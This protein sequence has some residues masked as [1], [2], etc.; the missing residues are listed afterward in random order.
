MVSFTDKLE[1]IYPSLLEKDIIPYDAY[2]RWDSLVAIDSNGHIAGIV[3]AHDGDFYPEAPEDYVR[4]IQKYITNSSVQPYPV[5]VDIDLTQGCSSDCTFCF[6]REYRKYTNYKGA[7]IKEADLKSIFK[8][9][10]EWGTTTIRFCGGGDPLV[11]PEIKS[12]LALPKKFGLKLTVITNGDLLNKEIS[13]LIV[14]NVDHLRWSVNAGVNET[15]ELIHRPSKNAN[16]L[17][18][19]K[20]WI[21]YIAEESNLLSAK[22]RTMIWAT[23]LLMPENVHEIEAAIILLKESKVNSISFRP[24]FHGLL[25]NWT[26]QEKKD[27]NAALTF[28]QN[29]SLPPTF[30]VFTPSR[31]VKQVNEFAPSTHFSICRSR[32]LRTVIEACSEGELL[33]SCGIY[34]GNYST[35]QF[36]T[37]GSPD[38][39]NAWQTHTR[40]PIPLIAPDSCSKC[41]DISMN[42]TLEFIYSMLNQNPATKFLR[43]NKKQGNI[44]FKEPRRSRGQ[45]S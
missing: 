14:S 36:M 37:R 42:Q 26:T 19:T 25:R 33:Q 34:R 13:E 21:K 45:V 10:A 18:Q 11:H 39:G 28:A 9:C 43:A 6:S 30:N 16:R 12:L 41:I 1:N 23:Y 17:D 5:R 38:F 27:L 4:A 15:R 7:W 24:V 8:Q 3:Q 29:S 22:D 35:G 20:Y 44:D 40:F 32:F 31:A 2:G